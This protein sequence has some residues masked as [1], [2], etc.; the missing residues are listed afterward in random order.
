MDGRIEE[1]LL[2][3]VPLTEKTR[4]EDIFNA[5]LAIV[6][7]FNLDLMKLVSVCTD[8]APAMIGIHTGFAALLKNH[9]TKHFKTDLFISYHC[10]IHQENLCASALEK[11]SDVLKTVTK[12]CEKKIAANILI[13]HYYANNFSFSSDHQ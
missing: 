8:G 13:F 9:I 3:S 2:S 10:I 12:V 4:A 11:N 7:R 1:N 6:E 5:F